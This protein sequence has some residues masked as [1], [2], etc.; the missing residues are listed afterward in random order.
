MMKFKIL[1][2]VFLSASLNLALAQ[3]LDLT[4]R[5]TLP[6]EL[7]EISGLVVMDSLGLAINDSGGKACLYA[8]NLTTGII[9][10][11]YTLEGA[12]NKDFEALTESK[13]HIFIGDIGN[14]FASRNDFIIYSIAKSELTNASKSVKFSRLQ[15][16]L[17]N[18]EPMWSR[19]H[20]FDMESMHC[21]AAGDS[22]YIYSKNR[23]DNTIAIY[24]LNTKSES[25]ETLTMGNF[26]L[27]GMITA[28][29]VQ[30]QD[31]FLLTYKLWKTTLY[32]IPNFRTKPC[33]EWLP[34][35]INV[36][37]AGY[38]RESLFLTNGSVFIASES[39]RYQ[40]QCLEHYVF[41]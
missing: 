32:K 11:R 23:D 40:E 31:L 10:Y 16:T 25:Q 27:N 28:A 6:D 18:Y 24:A 26:K 35:T 1:L 12:K 5:I 17:P 3:R 15:F 36:P 22:L 19:K 4:E 38:Q 33:S 34:I 29:A 13:T 37:G 8:F 7:D 30:G 20:N 9:Q 39:T 14:N 21:N 41:K 2:L